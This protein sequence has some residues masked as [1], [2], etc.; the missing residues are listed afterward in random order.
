MDES[1]PRPAPNGNSDT[2]VFAPPRR[3]STALRGHKISPD[4]THNH[5]LNPTNLASKPAITKYS[6]IKIKP[7][8]AR[9]HDVAVGL[10]AAVGSHV[11][12]SGV[13]EQTYADVVSNPAQ[14]E[15]DENEPLLGNRN[16]NGN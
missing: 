5:H 1:D 10:V 3:H 4:D 7:G 6:T 2:P 16:D 9:N 15:P 8:R 13:R 12:E 11:Q 14:N